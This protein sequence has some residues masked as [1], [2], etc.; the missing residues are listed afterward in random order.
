MLDFAESFG[1]MD[2][3]IMKLAETWSITGEKGVA[4]E[5]KLPVGEKRPQADARPAIATPN[6]AAAA[7]VP[8]A[9]EALFDGKTL[10][11]WEGDTRYWSVVDGA[12]RGRSTDKSNNYL[13]AKGEFQNF[14]LQAQFKFISGNSGI[15]FRCEPAP[16]GQ[17]QG[18]YQAAIYPPNAIGRLALDQ[19]VLVR[20]DAALLKKTYRPADWNSYTI[21]AS[22]GHIRLW[23]NDQLMVDHEHHGPTSGRIALK[24][25]GPTE[26]YFRDLRLKP[27]P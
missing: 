2:D 18:G 7:I 9:G 20:P 26:V 25:Y 8:D 21:E 6:P 3:L 1:R 4:T 10:A 19:K 14:R 16:A 13:F 12:I 24:L 23:I 15:H 22:G 17:S 5:D 11:G 27:L